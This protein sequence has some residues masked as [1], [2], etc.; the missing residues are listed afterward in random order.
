MHFHFALTK[1]AWSWWGSLLELLENVANCDIIIADG[2][3]LQIAHDLPSLHP[4]INMLELLHSI[5]TV[6]GIDLR[7]IM[8][9]LIITD[10][11]V[12]KKSNLIM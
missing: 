10:H 9:L 11:L 6:T 7:Y 12:I 5:I 3:A 2:F 1:T 8:S 4:Y